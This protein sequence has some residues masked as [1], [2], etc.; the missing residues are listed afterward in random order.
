[1]V[2]LGV[3]GGGLRPGRHR[4][5]ELWPMFRQR[6]VADPRPCSRQGK[7]GTSRPDISRRASLPPLA[8]S[9]RELFLAR[10]SA[11]SLGHV[12]MPELA[13]PCATLPARCCP[14]GDSYGELPSSF[15]PLVVKARMK[16]SRGKGGNGG[17]GS[18]N[19]NGHGRGE[20]L[21]PGRAYQG[22]VV[23]CRRRLDVPWNSG[24]VVLRHGPRCSGWLGAQRLELTPDMTLF[25]LETRRKTHRQCSRGVSLAGR[26]VRWGSEASKIAGL[27]GGV[28]Q[29]SRWHC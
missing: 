25:I 26:S 5:Q 17:C 8:P 21:L 14:K 15:P 3:T 9:P 6:Y 12:D 16:P 28:L 10:D 24:D 11:S 20:S 7:L 27:L 18:P 22:R 23:Q 1:M 19:P 4:Y 2:E 13:G 29:H